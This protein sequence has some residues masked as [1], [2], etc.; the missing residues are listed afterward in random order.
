MIAGRDSPPVL[1]GRVG[2]AEF[3]GP[4]WETFAWGV[5]PVISFLIK[6][7]SDRSMRPKCFCIPMRIDV[8]QVCMPSS[9]FAAI[10]R[11]VNSASE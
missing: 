9:L 4:S 7:R 11:T 1:I 3:G 10:C 2:R 5:N 8:R 6:L